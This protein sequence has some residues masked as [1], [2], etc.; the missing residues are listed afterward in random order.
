MCLRDIE[1]AVVPCPLPK[2]LSGQDIGQWIARTRAGFRAI[3]ENC[4]DIIL[5]VGPDKRAAYVSPSCTRL[6]GWLPEELIGR[7]PE[8]F[9]LPQYIAA[10]DEDMAAFADRGRDEGK[11]VIQARAKDGQLHWLE[12][13]ARIV[14]D[15][16]T[17]QM[18]RLIVT[19]REINDR[20]QFED[21]MA[22]LAM[23][24]GLTGVLNRRA[25]DEALARE[26][27]H[28][29]QTSGQMSLLLLDID[30]FKDFNDTYG[31]QAGDDCLRVVAA[32]IRNNLGRSTDLLARYG[33]E[34]FAAILPDADASIAVEIAGRVRHAIADMKIPH[35]K[36]QTGSGKVTAS[37]GA[38]TALS[39]IG[40]T[41]RM[42]EGLLLAADTAL[43]KA[44]RNG[45]NRVETAL[46]LAP[47]GAT[48]VA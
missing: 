40:G 21:Q 8:V 29:V 26:W 30:H 24:D 5:D 6:L 12:S 10:I 17:G 47:G 2:A 28:T 41:I 14:R 39:R 31:H 4:S 1:D 16:K 22:T 18:N 11:L 7:G 48:N 15:M 32:S 36:S 27:A 9:I 25:F 45:R 23:T 43:Y 20:K 34:E 35:L 3:A 46:L 42:P 38:A 13:R 19:M 37:I 33:G 44:K